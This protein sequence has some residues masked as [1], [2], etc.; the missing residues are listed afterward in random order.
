MAKVFKSS[1][2]CTFLLSKMVPT[3]INGTLTLKIKLPRQEA[4][5]L[6][7]VPEHTHSYILGMH[8]PHLHK[9][10]CFWNLEQSQSALVGLYTLLLKSA[11]SAPPWWGF[12]CSNTFH[13]FWDCHV[14][15]KATRRSEA[16]QNHIYQWTT[17]VK[18]ACNPLMNW[19][20]WQTGQQAKLKESSQGASAFL[21]PC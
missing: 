1:H 3:L 21:S 20:P 4:T 19:N 18:Q 13:D 12:F 15:L 14:R 6:Q 16:R 11:T 17:K 7:T 2:S 5:W 8:L 10:S 9:V